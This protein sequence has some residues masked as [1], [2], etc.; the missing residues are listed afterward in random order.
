MDKNRIEIL[1]L[2]L[3]IILCIFPLI[4]KREKRICITNSNYFLPGKGEYITIE[5]IIKFF[6][7][8]ILYIIV[9]SINILI[10]LFVNEKVTNL[11]NLSSLNYFNIYM[12]IWLIY[13]IS[14]IA[15]WKT[16][17]IN[18][19]SDEFDSQKIIKKCNKKVL[20]I[21]SLFLSTT[22]AT[23]IIYLLDTSNNEY[24]IAI[25]ITYIFFP[26]IS[27]LFFNLK[28]SNTTDNCYSFYKFKVYF[29]D[30][31]YV[32]CDEIIDL[33]KKLLLK[34]NWED[35]ISKRANMIE[36]NKENVSL[37]ASSIRYKQY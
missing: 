25:G 22:C 23:G 20:L 37:I 8:L 14:L 35:S 2:I 30:N 10:I 3:P 11:L 17:K 9:T 1:R 5:K 16:I 21:I 31:A 24:I 32:E 13:L 19:D 26:L 18:N 7:Y 36:V 15:V 34:I 27:Y 12:L 29:K 33:G 28:F 4:I 6:G